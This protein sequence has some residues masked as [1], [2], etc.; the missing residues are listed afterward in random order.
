[1]CDALS[2]RICYRLGFVAY[3]KIF[4]A[5]VFEMLGVFLHGFDIHRDLDFI[6]E[7]LAGLTE[8]GEIW[9]FQ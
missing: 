3:T 6:L 2:S 1:M 9:P 4:D 5:C 7:N 8:M